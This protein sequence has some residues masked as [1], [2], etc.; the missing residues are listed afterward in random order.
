MYLLELAIIDFIKAVVGLAYIV[1]SVVV[2]IACIIS[3]IKSICCK[4]EG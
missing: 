2:M 3:D 4:K 1:I